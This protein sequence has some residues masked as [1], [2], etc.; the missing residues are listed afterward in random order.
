MDERKQSDATGEKSG[1]NT[2]GETMTK[3]AATEQARK[4]KKAV[5]E[6]ALKMLAALY[7]VSVKEIGQQAN[8]MPEE[9]S[10]K[11]E[12]ETQYPPGATVLRAFK[13]L[14]DSAI[15]MT[16]ETNVK[17]FLERTV[18]EATKTAFKAYPD[19]DLGFEPIEDEEDDEEDDD[20]EKQLAQLQSR[21]TKVTGVEF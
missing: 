2:A 20:E 6:D 12:E 17:K 15:P 8:D 9:D 3:P 10:E 18:K 5:P 11:G 21:F 16:E 7:G 1:T 4:S 14:C 19:L 13:E